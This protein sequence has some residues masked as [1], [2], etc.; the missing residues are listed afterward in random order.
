M[1]PDLQPLSALSAKLGND[2]E[3]VQAAGG[4]TSIKSDDILWVKA[5][6]LWLKDAETRDIFV[7]VNLAKLHDNYA[8]AL[9]DP[10]KSTVIEAL[11]PNGL[12][13]SIETSLHALMPQQ[14][15]LHTHSVRTIALAIREDWLEVLQERLAGLA[16]C[17]VPYVKPG[18]D[19]TRGLQHALTLANG[20]QHVD[21]AILGNHGL[22][23]AGNDLAAAAQLLDDVERRLD[24]PSISLSV[25]HQR[26][27]PPE[28]WRH[29]THPVC[30]ALA[31]DENMRERAIGGSLYPDH[32]IFLGSAATTSEPSDDGPKLWLH[33]RAGA[34][35]PVDAGPSADEMALCLALVLARVPNDAKLRYI[36]RDDEAALLDWDAEKYRQALA[37]RD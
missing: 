17:A 24:A 36:S 2:P 13:P 20:R 18:L 32:V 5:S 6:G 29:V 25:D 30:D 11:N 31:F 27:P 8:K 7:P 9:N 12:R 14:C 23:V 28:G 37:K 34:L 3:Q 15:V 22:V 1:R 19:L 33:P 26:E 10:V 35:L 4:N 21:I 16:W